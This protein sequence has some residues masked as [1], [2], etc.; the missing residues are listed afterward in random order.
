M[1][2]Y[3]NAHAVIAAGTVPLFFVGYT[4]APFVTYIHL[5]LPTYARHSREILTRYTTALPKDALIDITTMTHL[6][7]PRVTRMK[8]SELYRKSGRLGIANYARDT[9][10][11]NKKRPWY[12]GKIVSQFG[13]NSGSRLTSGPGRTRERG[14]WEIIE[15]SKIEGTRAK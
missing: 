5:H 13:I 9:A 12:L 11:I 6:G 14:V 3:S 7:R 4:T 1:R 2:A 8:I 15:K 10:A